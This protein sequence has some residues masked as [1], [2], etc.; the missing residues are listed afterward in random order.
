MARLTL[1]IKTRFP[2]VGLKAKRLA[3]FRLRNPVGG[4]TLGTATLTPIE[5][6]ATAAGHPVPV[7]PATTTASAGGGADTIPVIALL[8]GLVLIAV[9]WTASLRARRPCV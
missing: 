9:A 3:R 2:S 4:A 8:L 6:P 5:R 7:P 1:K